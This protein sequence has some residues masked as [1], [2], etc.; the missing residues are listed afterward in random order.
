M[1]WHQ[2]TQAGDFVAEIVL[3][4]LSSDEVQKAIKRIAFDV[5]SFFLKDGS[6][7]QSVRVEWR[8]EDERPR[9]RLTYPG[10]AWRVGAPKGHTLDR[11]EVGLPPGWTAA[12]ERFAAVQK[13]GVA[14]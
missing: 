1:S 8:K 14:V 9:V 6:L 13:Y 7:A 12:S 3:P 11:V 4:A 10:L 2:P 5:A